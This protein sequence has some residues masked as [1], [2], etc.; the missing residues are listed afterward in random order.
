MKNTNLLIGAGV[1]V[2]IS[3]YLFKKDLGGRSVYEKMFPKEKKCVKYVTVN[4]AVAPCPPECVEY[5]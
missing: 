3:V 4:C 2:A 5:K 1:L